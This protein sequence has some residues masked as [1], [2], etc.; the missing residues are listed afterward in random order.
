MPN[1]SNVTNLK[2]KS[3]ISL[4]VSLCSNIFVKSLL[5]TSILAISPCTLTLTL[6]ISN[7]L[8]SFSASSTFFKSSGS[9]IVS[10]GNLVAKHELEDLF[11]IL[12]QILC[13]IFLYHL[14]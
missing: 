11:Q 3:F 5:S 7:F 9:S 12:Y 4:I 13:Y 14:F 6:S 10:Y 1:K 8:I 2:P